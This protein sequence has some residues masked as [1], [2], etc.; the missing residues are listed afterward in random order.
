MVSAL[1]D[2]HLRV[3]FPLAIEWM[4]ATTVALVLAH[5]A[6]EIA[7]AAL[8]GLYL[9]FVLPFVGGVLWGLPVGVLQWMVLRRHT[10]DTGSWIVFSL[11]GFVG[12]WT[13]AMILAAAL[14]VPPTG[15]T[16]F[17]TF[18]SFAIPT[19]LIG[20]SQSRVLRGWSPHT[21]WWVLASTVGW[22][23]LVAVEMFRNH[24]LSGVNQLASRLVSGIAGYAVASGV[25]A[26]L[27]GGILAGAVT[28]IALSVILQAK[29]HG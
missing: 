28:G 26:T 25:G 23:G 27:L 10:G 29:S 2:V 6:L 8:L 20:W 11:L 4:L 5:L 3:R 12:A 21:R 19:P 13:M 14:F 1:R 24:A 22:S 9:L 16:E 7:A 18:L 17:R 15:L